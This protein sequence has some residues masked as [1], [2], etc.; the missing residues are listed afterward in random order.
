MSAHDPYVHGHHESVVRSHARRTV[1]DSAA[2]LIPHLS[3][4]MRVLDVGSGPGTITVDLA[5]RVHPGLVRG[6]D[7]EPTMAERATGLA[8]SQ[9]IENVEFDT[10]SGYEID[11]PDDT[12]DLVHAHQVLQH[13][14]D[15]SRVMAEMLR[16]VKPGGL[17]AVRDAIYSGTVWYPDSEGLDSW[18]STYLS[19]ARYAH[20]DPD[21]G[22]RLRAIALHAGATIVASS[23]SVWC[24]SA[25]DE[26]ESWGSAW[27]ERATDSHF[28]VM[29]VESGAAQ[30][31]D[32][33]SM[34]RAWRK[35]ARD[36][37]GWF[38]IPHGEVIARKEAAPAPTA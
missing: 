18:R 9:G 21:I 37:S 2:Y 30:A 14:S 31:D 7:V 20:G 6:I 22:R 35:W 26:R 4:G 34:S 12:F 33:H 32:L 11:S 19:A 24:Y 27:A 1:E 15:P 10:G 8:E 5:R 3:R 38:A 29:A 17:V 25:E 28:A 23:A 36:E 13:V 16:V